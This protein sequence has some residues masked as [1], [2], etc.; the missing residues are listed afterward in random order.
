M[1]QTFEAEILDGLRCSPKEIPCKYF[2]DQRGSQ[3]F[4]RI[5]DLPEYYPMRTE[6]SIMDRY[7]DEMV[8][9][10]GP[11]VM[12]VEYG[13][14]SSIKTR[15][16]LERLDDPVAYVPVDI[17][18][19]HLLLSAK[20]IADDFPHTEVLPVC[21]DF[22][23]DFQLPKSKREPTHAAVY[24]PG[25]TIGNFV[26]DKAQEVLAKI[27]PLC[28]RRGGLLIGIDLQKDVDVLERAYNDSRG[29]TAEFNLNLLHRIGRELETDLE[30]DGFRH[31]S[32]YNSD[33][34]RI[35]IYIRSAR[36]QQVRIGSET[37]FF[38]EDELIHT[39]YS[40]K[41]TIEEFAETARTAGLQLRKSWT[42]ER[43]YFAV[44]HLITID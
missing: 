29:V 30:P 5:C 34:H 42:D 21:A 22:T 8:D 25:S 33:K 23:E 36:E 40:H 17:S 32:F 43:E 38:A 1:S 19:E 3:L 7:V 26:P 6:Q 9:Q 11:G 24:F 27:A 16:L 35:E 44:L 13:S 2:Y 10:I 20:Q 12:L 28:G 39:E 31:H 15:R 14:G 37:F 41:Y 18:R 4:D